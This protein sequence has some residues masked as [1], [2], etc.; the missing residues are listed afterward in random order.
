MDEAGMNWG[1][2]LGPQR[3]QSFCVWTDPLVLKLLGET[4][5]LWAPG[6]AIWPAV[7]ELHLICTSEPL[8]AW[9]RRSQASFPLGGPRSRHW[10]PSWP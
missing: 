1:R 8:Q 10:F 2:L 5:E 6:A 9:Q 4:Q 7:V 3:G